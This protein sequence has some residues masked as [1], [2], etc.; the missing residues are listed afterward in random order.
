M[1]VSRIKK[2][3]IGDFGVLPNEICAHIVGYLDSSSAQSFSKTCRGARDLIQEH[4]SDTAIEQIAQKV[5]QQE[6]FSLSSAL[7]VCCKNK[8][9]V[10]NALLV[11][12][13]GKNYEY[14]SENLQK[15]LTIAKMAAVSNLFFGEGISEPLEE[16]LKF[17]DA[18]TFLHNLRKIPREQFPNKETWKCDGLSVL[19]N[20]ADGAFRGDREVVIAL[21]GQDANVTL[22]YLRITESELLKDRAIWLAAVGQDAAATIEHLT[23]GNPEL[24]KDKE[25]IIAL[26]GQNAKATLHYLR[27]TESEL[28]K[29]RAIWLAAAGQDATATFEHLTEIN[30]ELLKDKK[31]IITLMCKKFWPTFYHLRR[32]NPKLLEDKEIWAVVARANPDEVLSY[33]SDNPWSCEKIKQELLKDKGFFLTLMRGGAAIRTLKYLGGIN[34]ELLKDQ[35]IWLAAACE[36][37]HE[38]YTYLHSFCSKL[39]KWKER[40]F[41]ELYLH[42]QELCGLIDSINK[43]FYV[44]EDIKNH[45]LAV[46]ENAQLILDRADRVNNKLEDDMLFFEAAQENVQAI[47]N[48]VCASF[49]QLN[50]ELRL[51]CNSREIKEFLETIGSFKAAQESSNTILK[52]FFNGRFRWL[53]YHEIKSTILE[54]RLFMWRIEELK[55]QQSEVNG[56]PSGRSIVSVI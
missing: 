41:E 10:C 9:F 45:L 28:L 30:S 8:K 37:P 18:Q 38:T 34:H 21:A 27:N 22:S 54:D 2:F 1:A 35:E 12:V 23:E 15:D 13:D 4:M 29:D 44:K 17:L 19:F 53:D 16:N 49:G 25:I 11:D 47:S 6:K 7:T 46:R 33:L 56:P 5:L 3:E 55:K 51:G 40:S 39:L 42:T 26:A 31:I 43:S 50:S 36:K 14:V 52:A 32:N 20:C 48:H 24:L